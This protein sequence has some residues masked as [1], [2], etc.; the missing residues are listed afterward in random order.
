MSTNYTEHYQ[1]CQWEPEDK[2]LRTD[3]NEDNQRIE[4]ALNGQVQIAY[5][6]YIGTGECGSSHPKRLEFP[7]TPVFVLI[8][9]NTSSGFTG[10][11][12]LRGLDRGYMYR[13]LDSYSAA[14]VTWEDRAIQ[15][16]YTDAVTQLNTKDAVYT[17]FVIGR[18][19]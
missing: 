8:Y 7:F 1:L 15:W 4:A 19:E 10:Y 6:Q 5:G 12:W 18:A 16:Y 17:Y 14:K 2:V 9:N 3:F 13:S 11:P